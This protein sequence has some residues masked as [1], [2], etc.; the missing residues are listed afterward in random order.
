MNDIWFES[1]PRLLADGA[2]MAKW[3]LYIKWLIILSP[4]QNLADTLL[5]NKLKSSTYK[6]NKRW[7]YVTIFAIISDFIHLIHDQNTE[8]NVSSC[9]ISLTSYIW[10]PDLRNFLHVCI[11]S[12][13][14]HHFILY[15]T[16]HNGEYTFF[17]VWMMWHGKGL[18]LFRIKYI[19]SQRK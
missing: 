19:G 13:F 12:L 5:R 18:K 16:F 6:L 11:Q 1:W 10:F 9:L 7:S 15:S 2:K 3:P 14:A 8:I 17:L 4:Q